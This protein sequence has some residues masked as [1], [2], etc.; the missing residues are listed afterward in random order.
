MVIEN[1]TRLTLQVMCEERGKDD[2]GPFVRIRHPEISDF[3]IKI[4]GRD[5]SQDAFARFRENIADWVI[6]ERGSVKNPAPG[7]P[8]H[9]GTKNFMFFWNFRGF[10]EAPDWDVPATVASEAPPPDQELFPEPPHTRAPAATP[11]GAAPWE[12][13]RAKR[14]SIE[15]QQALDFAGRDFI[16][17]MRLTGD[18]A[19]SQEQLSLNIRSLAWDYMEFLGKG[20]NPRAIDE[21]LAGEMSSDTGGEG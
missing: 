11:Q 13:E 4:S 6:L 3:A 12:P 19:L 10:T 16:E 7:K 20:H 21:I 18:H 9:D 8:Q 5:L 17:W 1:G 2:R 14:T 15:R